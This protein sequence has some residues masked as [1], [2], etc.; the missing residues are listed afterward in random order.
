MVP[1]VGA[2][3]VRDDTSPRSA[4]DLDESAT[5]IEVLVDEHE[6]I[7]LL[8]DALVV[9]SS[10]EKP[11]ILHDLVSS[12]VKHEVAEEVVVYPAARDA[13][14][15]GPQLMEARLDEQFALDHE[16][17]ELLRLEVGSAEFV[18]M[19][20]RVERSVHAHTAYEERTV[21]EPLRG[22]VTKERLSE[23][24]DQYARAR[25][26]APSH[27]YPDGDPAVTTARATLREGLLSILG[28]VRDATPPPSA[29]P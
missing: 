17:D 16:L 10:D 6:R 24:L 19:L 18:A 25:L 7:H 21:L 3:R 8:F 22:A 23:L 29:S 27:P 12:I 15:I 13:G 1:L 9:A 28:R 5:L 20:V 11:A 14:A 2:G 26:A 4:T